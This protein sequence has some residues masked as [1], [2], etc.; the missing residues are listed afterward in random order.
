M[1]K[2]L[3]LIIACS[4]KVFLFAQDSYGFSTHKT[5]EISST[6]I[7][8]SKQTINDIITQYAK[9]VLIKNEEPRSIYVKLSIENSNLKKIDELL[10][11]V[12]YILKNNQNSESTDQ[13][14]SKIIFDTINIR[15]QIN[16]IRNALKS[17]DT[18]KQEAQQKV[19]LLNN[20]INLEKQIR[21]SRNKIDNYKN[22]IHLTIVEIT[23]RDET[24]VGDNARINYVNMPG[25]EYGSLFTESPKAGLSASQYQGFALKYLFTRGKSYINIAAFKDT[26]SNTK[27]S[28]YYNSLFFIDFG[29]DFYPRHFGRGKRKFLNLYTGYQIGGYYAS[30]YDV[31]KNKFITDMKV[32]IGLEIIKT[33]YILLDTKVNYLI[34]FDTDMQN[35]RG[36]MFNASFNFVF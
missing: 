31:S 11:P 12:G 32:D 22:S 36:L 28:S 24:M 19:S 3:L 29:Q 6:D 7:E 20:I 1:K 13:A 33:K 5:V 34:P 30:A 17:L 8:K 4:F 15:E 18:S 26:K 9:T 16:D 21:E 14:I 23:V 25:I 2:I 27:D 35:L 10:R